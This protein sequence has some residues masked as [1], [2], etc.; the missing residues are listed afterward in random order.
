MD[1]ECTQE[2]QRSPGQRLYVCERVFNSVCVC[3]FNCT[4]ILCA[5]G[6]LCSEL[7]RIPWSDG[8]FKVQQLSV[9]VQGGSSGHLTKTETQNS[10]AVCCYDNVQPHF[11]PQQQGTDGNLQGCVSG[12]GFT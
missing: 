6:A 7:G 9:S 2:G 8:M 10:D 11:F 5:Y 1:D 3:E 4:A 12:G